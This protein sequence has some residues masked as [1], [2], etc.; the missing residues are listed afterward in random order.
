MAD[1]LPLSIKKESF[2]SSGSQRTSDD[3]DS[4]DAQRSSV[5]TS[6]RTVTA[7]ASSSAAALHLMLTAS[8]FSNLNPK[9]AG[10]T[11]AADSFA[12]IPDSVGA[13]SDSTSASLQGA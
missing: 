6:G 2:K 9:R 1:R 8:P 10:H 11:S 3:D 13:I 12:G 5:A 7:S 4:G